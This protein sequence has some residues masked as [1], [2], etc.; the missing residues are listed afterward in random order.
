MPSAADTLSNLLGSQGPLVPPVGFAE[1]AIEGA[2][3]SEIDTGLD[4]VG[5]VDDG[6][7]DGREFGEGASEGVDGI[8]ELASLVVRNAD[9]IAVGIVGLVTAYT[10]GQL[11]TFNFNIGDSNA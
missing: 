9:V 6:I 1:G 2:T 3:D 4:R 11:F 10:V 7:D 5:V 8:T